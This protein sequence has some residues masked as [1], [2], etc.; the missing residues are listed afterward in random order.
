MRRAK[1]RAWAVGQAVVLSIVCAAEAGAAGGVG[2]D[3]PPSTLEDFALL[4]GRAAAEAAG[5]PRHHTPCVDGFAGPY[6][7]LDVDLLAVLPLAEIG[8]GNGTDLWGWT[9]P[10]SGR[11]YALFARTNGTSFIDVTDPEAPVYLGDLP[12]H[13]GSAPQRDV[14]V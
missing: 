1:A 6:P 13:S 11:E 2:D 7:C 9:D 4:A 12:S 5:G 14:K 10:D 3:P 8:G